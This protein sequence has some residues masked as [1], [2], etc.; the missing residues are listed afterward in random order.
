M[1]VFEMPDRRPITLPW[2]N[3]NRFDLYL[4]DARITGT[5]SAD[6]TRLERAF[7]YDWRLWTLTEIVDC[8]REAGFA[9]VE[10]YWEGT[11]D[12]GESGDGNFR[13]KRRG[14]NCLSWMAGNG[15][16][17]SAEAA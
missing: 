11:A 10:S 7:T 16:T 12:D 1:L 5:I 2:V 15:T 4:I 14:E 6:G 17:G 9:N 13:K 3:D 8:L